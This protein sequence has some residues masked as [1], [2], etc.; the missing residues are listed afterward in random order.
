MAREYTARRM[1]LVDIGANLMHSSFREDLDA[2]L[3]R[4]REAGV[5]T[6][7]VTGT[8]VDE[9]GCA[10]ALADAHP[11]QLY[12]TAGVHPHRAS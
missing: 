12:A 7:I 4:S 8:P 5:Q 3:A 9:S 6:I 2:V 10:A 11:G 1:T